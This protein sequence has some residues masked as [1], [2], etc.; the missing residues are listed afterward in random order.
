VG[1]LCSAC[2]LSLEL[3]YFHSRTWAVL[4]LYCVLLTRSCSSVFL[5][6][7]MAR[8]VYGVVRR[9]ELFSTYHRTTAQLIHVHFLLTIILLIWILGL[10]RIKG[11]WDSRPDSKLQQSLL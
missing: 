6:R 3:F 2:I 4:E 5:S 8:F 9:I 10:I 11:F 1:I 7:P